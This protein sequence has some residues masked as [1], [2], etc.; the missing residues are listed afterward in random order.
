MLERTRPRRQE[1]PA[2]TGGALCDIFSDDDSGLVTVSH[3]LH[4]EQLPVGNLTIGQIRRRYGDRFDIDPHSQGQVDGREV[5]DDVV[6]RPGQL[7]LF[8]R[9]AG[10]K[11][12]PLAPFTL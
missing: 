6:V 7:L 11:G 5:G 10:E 1:S 3:G 12:R 8:V 4:T 2:P 9:P